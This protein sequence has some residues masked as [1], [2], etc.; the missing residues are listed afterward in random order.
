MR[1]VVRIG[2][3]WIAAGGLVA[4]CVGDS[5]AG[6]GA[7]SGGASSGDGAAS[8]S[9]GGSSGASISSGGS[10]GASS[11]GGVSSSS[12]DLDASADASTA[13]CDPAKDFGTPVPEPVVNNGD[14]EDYFA[15]TRDELTVALTRST[16]SNQLKLFWARRATRTENFP[17][18]SMVGL[19]SINT[20]ADPGLLSSPS[21]S[22]TGQFLYFGRQREAVL[23]LEVAEL[24]AGG[25]AFS[26][27]TA[28][29]F[30][31]QSG[32]D[33]PFNPTLSP[34]GQTLYAMQ[35]GVFNLVG[36]DRFGEAGQFGA[37]RAFTTGKA[38]H[39]VLSA[40]ELTLYYSND[41]TNVAR[42]TRADLAQPFDTSTGAEVASLN[43]GGT[44]WPLWLSPDGCV[45]Y[46]ASTRI[47]GSGGTDVWR[48][49]RP[50]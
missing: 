20:G 24:P 36:G 48:A 11:S 17:V 43:S 6:D 42:A 16:G 25:N 39:G 10:S 23:G 15:L 14:S 50:R 49:E 41:A 28:V 3:T 31:T 33:T 18:P 27:P 9:G 34:S 19:E 2:A 22:P 1:N 40:D 45:M 46:L 37:L 8:S 35:R 5:P 32:F 21:F 7:S 29:S 47:G 26:A 38:A 4:A 30:T 12:G 44:D 13:R